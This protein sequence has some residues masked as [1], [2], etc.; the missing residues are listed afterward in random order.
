MAIL[1]A[2]LA[3]ILSGAAFGR[4]V[5]RWRIA[6]ASGALG[7]A[8]AALAALAGDDPWLG[9]A[10]GVGAA[11]IIAR[12]ARQATLD[13]ARLALLALGALLA[14]R[15][16]LAPLLPL[17]PDEA[18]Y[19]DWSRTLDW[20]YYSKPGGIAWLI[21][22]WTALAGDSLVAL[23]LLGLLL[24]ALAL[25][26]AWMAAR[27]L[28]LPPWPATALAALLP[29]HALT[30]GLITTDVPLLA[31]WAWLLVLLLAA[32]DAPRWWQPPLAA[33]LLALGINA[34]YAMLYSVAALALM[35][36]AAPLRRLL[37][38]QLPALLVGIALG[39]APLAAWNA[40]HDWAGLRHVAGQA[41]G[42]PAWWRPCEY[43]GGQ[44]AV[45]FPVSLLLPWALAWAWRR[46]HERPALW[47]LAAAALAPLVILLAVSLQAKV[48]PN[49]AAMSWLPAALLAAAWLQGEAPRWARSLAIA[50]AGL[51]LLAAAL[52]SALPALR[53]RY[54][55][56]PPS[57]P[58]RKLAGFDELA[59]EV[60]AEL[61]RAPA[62]VLTGSYEL[63][64]ALAWQQRHRPRPFCANFGR[65]FHQY[66]LWGGP[67]EAERGRDAVFV[68][69]LARDDALAD[70]WRAR[71]PP[72]LIADF[73]GH[74]HPRLVRVARGGRVWRQFLVV[75]LVAFDGRLD[76]ARAAVRW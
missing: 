18:Q 35:L 21:A 66:D 75:R 59:A 23:R 22:A 67:G 57:V 39:L 14:L 73:A 3:G 24:A 40:A 17:A 30:A 71:L 58:E 63:A 32:L 60:E 62:F 6:A 33:L 65:R 10:L 50:G 74:D 11:A 16:A 45:G 34:K 46:R 5:Q 56:L 13:G 29:I 41:S 20:A 38:R 8:L 44:L 47:L 9:A 12:W 15:L 61:A 70:D 36:A 7:A 55:S 37:A 27:R 69:E 76:S 52:L 25:A 19:W 51:V 54:P 26:G 64:A 4:P 2:I 49:W 43:L 28:D 48:Q 42:S 31:C 72:G 53:A 68:L 1:W